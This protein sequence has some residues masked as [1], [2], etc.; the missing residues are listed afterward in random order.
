VHRADRGT[1][2][3]RASWNRVSEN[4]R[5]GRA[6][7]PGQEVSA[8]TG[9]VFLTER[10]D[11][12][13]NGVVGIASRKD[14]R[15]AQDSSLSVSVAQRREQFDG[16]KRKVSDPVFVKDRTSNLWRSSSQLAQRESSCFRS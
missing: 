2:R 8:H 13:P 12:R 7:E 3:S 14:A 9:V 1:D 10:F 5:N 4:V 16:W 11:D 15:S 6:G